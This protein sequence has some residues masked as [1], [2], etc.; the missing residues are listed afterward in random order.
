[1]TTVQELTQILSGYPSDAEVSI[2]AQTRHSSASTGVYLRVS[3]KAGGAEFMNMV[4]DNR[5]EG[6]L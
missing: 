2:D 5:Q 3:V 1:M 6:K 4:S